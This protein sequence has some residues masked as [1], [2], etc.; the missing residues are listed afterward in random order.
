MKA[1]EEGRRALGALPQ[2]AGQQEDPLRSEDEIPTLSYGALLVLLSH[3]PRRERDRLVE[4]A[5][6]Y[7]DEGGR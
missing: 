2:A 6:A 3:H 5:M 4:P 1:E 7:R